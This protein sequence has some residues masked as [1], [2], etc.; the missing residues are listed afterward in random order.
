LIYQEGRG[1]LLETQL[2]EKLIY[3]I[4]QGDEVCFRT[5]YD[6]YKS[7]VYNTAKRMTND[8][9]AAEDIMQEVFVI[10]YTK[11]Y[12]L[13]H[14]EAFEVWLYRIVINCCKNFYKKGKNVVVAEEKTIENATEEYC[15]E[16]PS[17]LLIKKER[18]E[19][20]MICISK[21]SEKLKTCIILYY[22]NEMSI[23]E[24]AETLECSEGTVKSRLFKG[25]KALE[26]SITLK[27]EG[28]VNEHVY[29]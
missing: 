22:F 26:K 27:M 23:R 11:I 1:E 5:L 6:M 2:V 20:L 8:E 15:E 12:K 24:I 14:I 10:I 29:R 25:K 19:E 21:L 13:K 28:E 4:T 16:T 18:N 7:K 17:Q 9:N 3:G